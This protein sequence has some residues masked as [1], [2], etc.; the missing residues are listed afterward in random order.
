MEDLTLKE[1]QEIMQQFANI[2]YGDENEDQE[3]LRAIERS[4]EIRKLDKLKEDL[5]L[6][7]N[8]ERNRRE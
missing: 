8:F 4:E 6:I 2:S 5:E 1:I 7:A 3:V